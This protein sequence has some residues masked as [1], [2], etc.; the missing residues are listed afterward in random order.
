MLAR[1]EFGSRAHILMWLA[2]QDPAASY[3]WM[4]YEHCA[5]GRYARANQVS[6]LFWAAFASTTAGQAMMEL[7]AMAMSA[8]NFGELHERARRQ[9]SL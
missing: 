9:W 2:D 1:P 4:S 5:C 7:N 6:N 3:D 8:R